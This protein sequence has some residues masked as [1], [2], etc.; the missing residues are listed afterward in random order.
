MHNDIYGI[1]VEHKIALFAD[2]VILFLNNLS[3]S[4]P[5]LLDLIEIFGK[6]SGYKVNHFQSSIM[7][8]NESEEKI[9]LCLYL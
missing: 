4:V 7:L 2:D 3:S 9:R 5:A 8:L 6:R 1:Q